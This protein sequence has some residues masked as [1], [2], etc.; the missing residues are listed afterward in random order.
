MVFRIAHSVQQMLL[1]L[2]NFCELTL[3][4]YANNCA[5]TSTGR[6]R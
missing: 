6:V 2:C 5:A 3:R 1:Q 4:P